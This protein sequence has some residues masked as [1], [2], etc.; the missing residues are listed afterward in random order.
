MNDE[1]VLTSTVRTAEK[2]R[3]ETLFVLHH[4]AEVE[5]R[6][7]YFL[8]G[9]DSLWEFCRKELK[10]SEQSANRR[11]TAMHLLS[12][13]PEITP[14][15]GS[16][17]LSL[18]T[19]V[20]A[21]SFFRQEAKASEPLSKKEK[22]EVMNDLQSKSTRETERKLL[23]RSSQPAA[24]VREKIR[25]LTETL[26]EIR[27]VADEKL[28]GNLEQLKGLLA[29]IDPNL[30][31]AELIQKMA[32]IALAKLDPA[33]RKPRAAKPDSNVV[34]SAPEVKP[35]PR[36][37]NASLKKQVFTRDESACTWLDPKTGKRCGCRFRLQLDPLRSR[38]DDRAE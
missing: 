26:T 23:S 1:A 21:A 10:Y 18:S 20:Q 35:E 22:L 11:I 24:S 31:M 37:A 2:E 34:H 15:V 4:L 16:S 33:R 12:E 30:S 19:L 6:K 38:R 7:L 25:P 28:M 27:F 3:N 36:T 13:V 14:Q 29:H 32:E 8:R 5:R 17:E 9:C